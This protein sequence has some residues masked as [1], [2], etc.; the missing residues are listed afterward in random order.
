VGFVAV[1]EERTFSLMPFEIT[2]SAKSPK[3]NS[4][5]FTGLK[6]DKTMHIHLAI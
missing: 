3:I 6:F 1:K 2:G 4:Q 5:S